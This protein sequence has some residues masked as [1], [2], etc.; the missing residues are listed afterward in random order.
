MA[1]FP[2][3]SSGN[4]YLLVFVD[5]YSRWV[6]LFGLRKAT[7]ETISKIM[8][9]EVFTRWG[10]PNYLLSDRGPQFVSSVLQEVCQEWGVVQRLTTAYHPQTNLTE[11]INRT[12]KTMM[13]SYVEEQHKQ[14]DKHL[15]EFRFALNSAVHESTGTT[16]AEINLGRPLR[17]PME[18]LLHPRDISPDDLCYD[19]TSE[20]KQMK[21]YVEQ[22]L[23][24]ARQRQKRNYDK[25]RRDVQYGNKDRV[26]L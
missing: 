18:V 19:K 9:N 1:P 11:R 22:K 8:I 7:A 13:A 21:A 14:W 4:V 26:W 15:T 3:S 23:K 17:G 5:Y 24:T 10:V 25:H 16:P 20:L 12:L 2:R 6:E